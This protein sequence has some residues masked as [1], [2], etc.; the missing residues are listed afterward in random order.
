MCCHKID[1]SLTNSRKAL[2]LIADEKPA[3][4]TQDP[5]QADQH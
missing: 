5:S 3:E 1:I 2:T 4:T